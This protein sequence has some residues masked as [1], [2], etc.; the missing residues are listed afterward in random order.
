MDEAAYRL[1]RDLANAVPC[2]FQNA[3]LACHAECEL[4][5]RLTLA[6]R[7]VLACS[8]PTA[9]V[10]CETLSELLRERATFPLR[11]HPGAAMTHA[12]EMRLQCGGLLGLQKVLAATRP[13]VHR[14][15]L[16]AHGEYGS[17]VE[18]PWARLVDSI[19][20][21]QARRRAGPKP[22]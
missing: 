22:S 5:L 7:E 3:L 17:L 15:V 11:L 21:W 9:R 4:A 8:R 18:L 6:E 19:V 1:K 13:D 2:V 14:M 16:Q 12:T 10:N 20:A